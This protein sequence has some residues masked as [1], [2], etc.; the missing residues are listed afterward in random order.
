TDPHAVERDVRITARCHQVRTGRGRRDW[1]A[2]PAWPEVQV[3]L[4]APRR[5]VREECPTPGTRSPRFAVHSRSF[6]ATRALRI[7]VRCRSTRRRLHRLV[8][9]TSV[10]PYTIVPSLKGSRYHS[11]WPA[12]RFPETVTRSPLPSLTRSVATEIEPR[13]GSR[14][15]PPP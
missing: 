5:L 11:R 1:D 8:V 6:S 12:A 13:T 4:A 7:D 15:R 10:I 3:A 2:P 14:S 9:R